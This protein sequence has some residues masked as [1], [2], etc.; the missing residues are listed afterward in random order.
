MRITLTWFQFKKTKGGPA[1]TVHITDST[2]SEKFFMDMDL[3]PC[4]EFEDDNWP[5]NEH[6]RKNSTKVSTFFVVPKKP[7]GSTSTD[8]DWRLSF[9]KQEGAILGQRQSLKPALKLLKVIYCSND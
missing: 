6:F 7:K 5:S 9:Q 4:F 8:K 2:T 1:F 3:V